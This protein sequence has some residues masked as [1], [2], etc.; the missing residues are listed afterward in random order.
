MQPGRHPCTPGMACC[1]LPS[2]GST[3]SNIGS[4]IQPHPATLVAPS[5]RRKLVLMSTSWE[6]S[7]VL[8]GADSQHTGKLHS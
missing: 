6:P 2:D 3:F 5:N 1:S 7:R 4:I 8:G